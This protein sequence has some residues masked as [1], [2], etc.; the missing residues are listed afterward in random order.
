MKT[1]A[2]SFKLRANTPEGRKQS[3]ISK[4]FILLAVLSLFSPL[5]CS[6]QVQDK[7]DWPQFLARHDL[8]WD[9]LPKAWH[10][11]AFIGNG[12]LGSM[13]YSEAA[14]TLQWDINRS[15]VADRGNRLQ[16]GRFVL[17]P[18]GMVQ[19]GT[20][21]LDLWNAEAHGNLKTDLTSVEWR[22]F[23]HADKIVTFIELKDRPAKSGATISFQHLQAIPAIEDF[24][25]KPIPEKER[26]PDAIFGKTGDTSWC[27]QNFTAGGGYCVAWSERELEPGHRLFAFTID[28]ALS[29]S[30][31]QNKA[32]ADVRGAM[33]AEFAILEKSHRNWW[34]SYWQRGAFVSIPDTRMESFYWIQ[35]YKLASG[36][37]ADRPALDVLG[38][39]FRRTPWPKIWWNLNIQLAYWPVYA[40]N[41]LELGESLTRILDAN[42]ANLI[43]NV[44]EAWR[45]DSAAINRTSTYDCIAPVGGKDGEERGNLIWTMHNY[46]LQYRHSGDETM[47]RER[48]YPLLKRSVAYFLHL[49]K[50]GDDGKLHMP[51]SLSPE[52]PKTAPDTNY[53][54]AL[55]RWGPQTVIA[56]DARFGLDDPFA[57][58]C[59]ETLAKLASPP[60]DPKDGF[61]IGAGQ[62]LD[63]S[64]R[65]FS[66]LFAIYPLHLLDFDA[67]ADRALAEKSID[68]W[69]GFEGALEGYSFTGASAMS[70]WLGRRGVNVK[71]LNEFLDRFVKMNTMYLE[72]GPVIETPLA[73][74]AAI[75]E[76]VLQSWTPESFGTQ[77][78]VFPAIPDDWKDVTIHRML[79]EGAFEVSAARRNGKTQ[80]VQITSLAGNPCLI[81]TG[82][83][84]PTAVGGS[85][86]FT[87]ESARDKNDNLVTAID[88]KKG[89][90]VLLIS[91]TAPAKSDELVIEPVSAEPDRC[92]FYGSRKIAAIAQAADGNIILTAKQAKLNGSTFFLQGKGDDMNI[93][94]WIK[95]DEY[96]SWKI[97]VTKPGTFA[98]LTKY[99][100]IGG[101]KIAIQ[102]LNADAATVGSI[103]TDK[104]PTG[105]W[106]KF[107]EHEAGLLSIPAAG[108]YEIQMR[109]ADG[110]APMLNLNGVRLI[111]NRATPA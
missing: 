15:D 27:L 10:E 95:P 37:R 2:S 3:R 25:N 5:I 90:T 58:R 103:T 31:S 6:A 34:H 99:S 38:P 86:K 98:V 12:L 96:L 51:D 46:W 29:G 45:E 43:N 83:D 40:S 59:R 54:L 110:N 8:V 79:A 102:V 42:V 61:M 63:I 85:R 19:K 11:G 84:E 26:N 67:P 39:W 82:L 52:F 81:R 41:H 14:N 35:M 72:A 57:A 33:K 47:L 91:A 111:A 89:E 92:N 44:P 74:A 107:T 100:S 22:S 13:I 23:T 101:G 60:I 21:R 88:L 105:D 70:S 78:R 50:P 109:S 65:H 68:H 24:E 36:T 106:N 104:I 77:I 4:T 18:A 56:C 73:G 64:H 48:F 20:M 17:T 93:G 69:I 66:H 76:I 71:L 53:D 16:I 108:T 32:A 30:P 55:L 62:P 49:L 80:F 87:I 7:I 94:Y 75:H 97:S 28:F 1:P 9:E